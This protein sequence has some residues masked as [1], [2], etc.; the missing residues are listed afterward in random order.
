MTVTL[1]SAPVIGELDPRLWGEDKP[2]TTVNP[3]QAGVTEYLI[4]KIVYSNVISSL[5]RCKKMILNRA[6]GPAAG[7]QLFNE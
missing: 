6:S 5:R 7:L 3:A 1:S 4:L 2:L